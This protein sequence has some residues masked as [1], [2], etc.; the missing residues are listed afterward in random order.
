MKAG[1]V[2]C[3]IRK[4]AHCDAIVTMQSVYIYL[5]PVGGHRYL[6]W[7]QI[8]IYCKKQPS[9]LCTVSDRH[10]INCAQCLTDTI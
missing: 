6:Q 1:T 4:N 3:T 10:H 9:K 2:M 8:K 7:I 5:F